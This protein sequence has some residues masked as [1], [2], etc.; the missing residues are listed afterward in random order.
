MT[1][2]ARETRLPLVDE[3]AIQTIHAFS[4][5]ES[6]HLQALGSQQRNSY[7]HEQIWL[8][9]LRRATT[10][11]VDDGFP[12]TNSSPTIPNGAKRHCNSSSF[13]RFLLTYV[14]RRATPYPA[15]SPQHSTYITLFPNRLCMQ[16][17]EFQLC[18]RVNRKVDVYE[19]MH[20]S[21]FVFLQLTR[22]Y[23]RFKN[24]FIPS[25]NMSKFR[26]DF[27]TSSFS[28]AVCIEKW[29]RILN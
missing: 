20:S 27:A 5:M 17:R 25:K 26:M 18:T 12:D 23:H 4:G 8:R 21:S 3:P 1:E 13:P 7:Y 6:R 2:A 24:F 15:L 16:P 10:S 14:F 28:V 29:L 22:R 11:F 9:L 19:G